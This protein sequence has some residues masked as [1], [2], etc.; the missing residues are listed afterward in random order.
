[1]EYVQTK[2]RFNVLTPEVKPANAELLIKLLEGISNNLLPRILDLIDITLVE[3]NSKTDAPRIVEIRPKVL[4]E[5]TN[6]GEPANGGFIYL[7]GNPKHTLWCRCE[8]GE[9]NSSEAG[10]RGTIYN[11]RLADTFGK[12]EA[13]EQALKNAAKVSGFLLCEVPS[14]GEG[15]SELSLAEVAEAITKMVRVA[16][17]ELL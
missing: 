11:H 5:L 13:Y 17:R 6:M 1:M 2:S 3:D 12:P 7:G 14:D 9:L 10:I 8:V 15:F 16:Y 4:V